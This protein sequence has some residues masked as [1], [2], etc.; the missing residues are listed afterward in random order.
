MKKWILKKD[1]VKILDTYSVRK[2]EFQQIGETEYC[3]VSSCVKGYMLTLSEETIGD[4]GTGR[5]LV[6]HTQG[7]GKRTFCDVWERDGKGTLQFRFRNPWNLPLSDADYIKDL[8]EQN[9]HL[10]RAGEELK[11]ELVLLK[12]QKINND[13]EDLRQVMELRKKLEELTK[14]NAR[15]AGRK[16]SQSR[17]DAMEKVK[18][19]LDTGIS[20][21]EI[22]EKLHISRATFYRYKRSIK[23]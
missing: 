15:G 14:H 19:M 23:N 7:N 12:S 5:I 20:D 8:E 9:K 16:P 6:S 3:Y 21:A 13:T 11:K 2:D 4:A 10:M 22:M 1:V 17:I 18:S